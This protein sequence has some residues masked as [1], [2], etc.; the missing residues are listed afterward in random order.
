MREHSQSKSFVTFL[1][2][3]ISPVYWKNPVKKRIKMPPLALVLALFLARAAQWLLWARAALAVRLGRRW[4]A[5]P[6]PGHSV[7]DPEWLTRQLQRCGQC[8]V[9]V[10]VAT[11]QPTILQRNHRRTVTR[12]AL[13]YTEEHGSVPAVVAGP[14]SVVLK[15]SEAGG[16][17]RAAILVAGEV[18]HN[19]P[20]LCAYR[21]RSCSACGLCS[22][23]LAHAP[24]AR[25]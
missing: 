10:Q 19:S 25:S 9:G 14:A 22:C 13:T 21:S 8:G 18:R 2:Y 6:R 12:L 24:P 11:I 17:A 1:E 7:V 4:A 5:P 23:L 16:E 3:G 15:C 20:L